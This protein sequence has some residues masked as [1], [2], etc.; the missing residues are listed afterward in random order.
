MKKISLIIGVLFVI[1]ACR[2]SFQE[3]RYP[4][5]RNNVCK[6]LKDDVLLFAVFVDSKGIHPWTEY[7]INS[8]KDSIKRAINWLEI[9]AV[10]NAIPLNIRF[11]YFSTNQKIPVRGKF[12]Y[13]TLSKTLFHYRDLY[14]G[15]KMVDKWSDEVSR[16]VARRLP[17]S[18][19]KV[20]L[21]QNNM[22]D[23]ER[24]IS[25]LRDLY[26]TDNVA[27]LFFT[28]NYF[29]NEISLSL[30]IA[31]NKQ[32]EYAILSEKRPAVIAHEFLHLFGAIDLYISP[33]GQSRQQ[34]RKKKKVMK[35]F[36]NEIMAFAYKNIDSLN[37]S[38]LSNYLIGW[39]NVL[40]D[41][42]KSLIARKH[43]KL[44]EY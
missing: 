42:V 13:E 44:L 18:K 28:N 25:L 3:V 21:T 5:V 11:E 29:E 32:T 14:K 34:V 27:L 43:Q 36:P 39:D 22:S 1:V 9:Q 12:K 20:I 8:T 41:D 4:T 30:H 10:K 7:D 37:L 33:F 23:R 6:A 16:V 2:V 24:L 17:K 40:N 35:R 31:S 26:K 38:S 15:I 19:S